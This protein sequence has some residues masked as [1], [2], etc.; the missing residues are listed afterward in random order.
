[1]RE[2]EEHHV[3]SGP[4]G[5]AIIVALCLALIGWGLANYALVKDA[6]RQWDYGALPQTP[7]S[8]IY[9]TTEPPAKAPPQ[10]QI[11]PLP[12]AQPLPKQEVKP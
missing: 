11:A 2:Y 8:S 3:V 7:A 4:W 10:R 6:P 5:W 12:D 9:S 1:M